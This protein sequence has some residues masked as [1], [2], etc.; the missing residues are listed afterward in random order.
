MRV[1]LETQYAVGTATGLG[2]YATGLAAALRARGDVDVVELRDDRFD[3]WRFDRR[4]YW[5]QLRVRRLARA[6]HADVIHFTGGTLPWNPPHPCV[7]TLHDLTWLRGANRGRPYVR[8]Y[9]GTWQARLARQADVIVVDTQA[10][11]GDV[12]DG[13]EVDPARIAVA[14]IG[15]DERFFAIDR[16]PDTTPLVLSVGTVERRKDLVTAV[17]AIARLDGAR[18]I[19]A[20]PLTPYVAEVRAEAERLGIADRVQLLGY[21]PDDRLLE[22]Y[23]RAS[24]FMF[25]SRYEGFGLPPLQALA[26]GVPVVASDIPVLREVL[27]NATHFATPGDAQGFASALASALGPGSVADADTARGRLRARSHSWRAVAE[28]MVGL[29]ASLL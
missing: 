4:V 8:W 1:A 5:D 26:A 20:G 17:R 11:K 12:A 25:P 28:R 14:G 13:L 9:F 7:L 10:A 2:V 22:L 29:Y 21:V 3:L 27:G 24:A 15:I 18:L 19:S 16:K 6:A 23:A